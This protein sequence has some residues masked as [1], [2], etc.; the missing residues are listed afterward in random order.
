VEDDQWWVDG[1]ELAQ[2]FLRAVTW[3]AGGVLED[4]LATRGALLSEPDRALEESWAGAR[5]VVGAGRADGQITLADGRVLPT[6]SGISG[7]FVLPFGSSVGWEVPIGGQ[8]TF[9]F[10]APL[11][12]D[13]AE[14]AELFADVADPDDIADAL[15]AAW[16][17]HRYVC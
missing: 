1:G 15:G 6:G 2:P 17:R 5:L 4:H 14:A 12:S 16:R 13:V 10:G 7:S 11:G 8:S 3:F 9:V